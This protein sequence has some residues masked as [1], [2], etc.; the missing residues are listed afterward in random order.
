MKKLLYIILIGLIFIGLNR[1]TRPELFSDE[2]KFNKHAV[3]NGQII[4]Q[5]QNFK[6]YEEEYETSYYVFTSNGTLLI[7]SKG[8]SSD[9]EDFSDLLEEHKGMYCTLTVNQHFFGRWIVTDFS[10]CK[11]NKYSIQRQ[12]SSNADVPYSEVL[13]NDK[14]T[15]NGNYNSDVPD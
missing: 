12:L 10:N 14:P 8:N 5:I 7:D 4:T 3:N 1:Y 2:N 15:S 13:Y 9:N 6:W 11:E